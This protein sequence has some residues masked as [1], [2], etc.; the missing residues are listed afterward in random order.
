MKCALISIVLN[1][2]LKIVANFKTSNESNEIKFTRT[3][4][5]EL[6]GSKY[7][8]STYP[9]IVLKEN[10]ETIVLEEMKAD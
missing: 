2:S 9:D 10:L 5:I 7:D 3:S 6:L 4:S 1:I 8:K